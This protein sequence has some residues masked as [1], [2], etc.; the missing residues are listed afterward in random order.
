MRFQIASAV[1]ALSSLSSLVSAQVMHVVSV[2]QNGQLAF[3]PEQITANPGDLVQFQFYPK[4]CHS[5]EYR[6]D[7]SRTTP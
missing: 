3:C 7:L 5:Q 1:I 6:T 4:V 2:G